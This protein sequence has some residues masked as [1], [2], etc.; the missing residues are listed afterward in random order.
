MISEIL[1]VLCNALLQR[2][3]SQ[4][5]ASKVSTSTETKGILS[6]M[7]IPV[8][9]NGN[10]CGKSSVSRHPDD[11]PVIQPAPEIETLTLPNKNALASENKREENF[12]NRS[13]LCQN[14]RKPLSGCIYQVKENIIQNI[15]QTEIHTCGGEHYVIT[16][17]SP[18]KITIKDQF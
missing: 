9:T 2:F 1:R 11:S 18:S 12:L 13:F 7:F 10:R 3:P 8:I 5:H 17:E 4:R 14:Y 6:I 16:K 15:C